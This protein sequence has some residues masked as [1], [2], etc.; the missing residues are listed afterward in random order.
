MKYIN[1]KG[2]NYLVHFET[3]G[4][5]L[6][7]SDGCF[8][9]IKI[10]KSPLFL[11]QVKNLHNEKKTVISSE[12]NWEEIEV[13]S[14]SDSYR[15]VFKAP[16]GI[17]KLTVT[18]WAAADESGLRW[19][20]AVTNQNEEIS[21]MEISYP[22][23]ETT[24]DRYDLFVPMM[25]GIVIPDAGVRGYRYQGVQLHM[26]FFAAYAGCGGLY[27]GIHDPAP[28]LKR[29]AVLSQDGQLKLDVYYTGENGMLPQNSFSLAGSCIWKSLEAGADWY[30]AAKIYA[31]FARRDAEWIPKTDENG[32]IDTPKKFKDIPFWVCDYIPNS[33]SQGDNKP[34]SLSAKSD[35]YAEDYWYQAVI[36]LQKALG[37]P[38]AY[39]VYNWH[40]IP[41]NVDY[42]HFLPARSKFLE[43]LKMLR[44]NNVLVTPYINALSWETRDDYDGKFDVTFENTGKY[45]AVKAEDGSPR[46]VRYPQTHS[47]GI[48]VQLAPMCPT[49]EKWQSLIQNLV[50]QMEDTL[51]IDG[52]YFDQISASPGS[53]CYDKDH[54]HPLGGGRYWCDGYRT[55]MRPILASKPQGSYYFSEDNTEGY[56]NL[57]DGFLTW[58]WIM[59]EAVPAFPAV[60]SGYIQ[61]IGRSTLG[62][63]KD[64]TEFFKYSLAQSFLYGQQLGWCKADVLYVE[65][66]LNFLKTLVTTRYQY[67]HLFHWAEML[68]PPRVQC[69]LKAKTTTPGLYFK[70]D[71]V[72]EQVL[73]AAWKHR[74]N[75]KTVIFIINIAKETGEYSLSFSNA[76]YGID[77]KLLAA[78]GFSISDDG[79][80]GIKGTIL[81]ESIIC[82][83]F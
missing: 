68:R 19:T 43:R 7:V 27:Y 22:R 58:R 50:H 61:T 51:D 59:S 9:G 56:M 29:Y 37:V 34:M 21:V 46:V 1:I 49:H 26:Q 70:T 44:E 39:H 33:P 57:F 65:D 83:E 63:K 52:I 76:E 75:K 60:Y 74:S 64:D 23:F 81:P 40:E 2:S 80:A 69:S 71:V 15:F 24:S 3:N 30:D 41:F 10:L 78:R 16:C 82:M 4:T 36:D 54:G 8:G 79:Q 14:E 45:G 55:M 18:F 53:P 11:M 13:V 32:R 72:M 62:A 42:P 67:R 25:S 20:G 5:S 28:A 73:A 47:D 66:R 38:I 12:S 35:I 31:N 6:S 17:D 48:M 77:E